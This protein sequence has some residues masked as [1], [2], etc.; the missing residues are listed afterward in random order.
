MPFALDDKDCD[1]D[2]AVTGIDADGIIKCAKVAGEV[3]LITE[4]VV[5]EGGFILP[6]NDEEFEPFEGELTCTNDGVVSSFNV[7]VVSG[8]GIAVIESLDLV[9]PDTVE[10]T[11]SNPGV[12]S[13]VGEGEI[14]GELVEINITGPEIEVFPYM[15]CVNTSTPSE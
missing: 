11:I 1:P 5:G 8:N 3:S 9:A 10:F 2:Q 7:L 15:F 4:L 12:G 14:N 6:S 13:F